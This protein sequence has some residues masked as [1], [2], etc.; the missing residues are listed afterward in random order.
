[1]RFNAKLTQQLNL[2]GEFKVRPAGSL[3]QL[4]SKYETSEK[5]GVKYVW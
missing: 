5:I 4:A 3:S 1:V 2:F